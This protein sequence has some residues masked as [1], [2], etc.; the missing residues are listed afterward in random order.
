[1]KKYIHFY[2]K[3]FMAD[4][5]FREWVRNDENE[6]NDFWE[7]WL[8]EHPEKQQDVQTARELLL[9]IWA[10]YD[11]ISDH[12]INHHVETLEN[13]L[14]PVI[15]SPTEPFNRFRVRNWGIAATMLLLIVAG[16]VFWRFNSSPTRSENYQQLI[17]QS[18][19]ATL[20]EQ[21]NTT[22]QPLSINLPDGSSVLLSP[23]SQIVYPDDMAKSPE[24][25]VYLIGE[26]FFEVQRNPNKPFMVLANDIVTRVLG[27]SFW[28]R[29]YEDT[30]D[31]SVSVKTGK[32][33]VYPRQLGNNETA[34]WEAKSGVLLA[35]N[36]EVKYLRSDRRLVKTL[37]EN[38]LIVNPE[39]VKTQ[40]VFDDAPIAKVFQS[41]EKAYGIQIVYDE[42]TFKDCYITAKIYDEPLAET[43]QLLCKVINATSEIVDGQIVITG[44]GC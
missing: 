18:K 7:K 43:L 20:I 14:N 29:S 22:N 36:Q 24:R 15:S 28:V 25:Q 34:N 37:V 41:L 6:P 42:E 13:K 44:K 23:Q 30:P 21:K 3:D 39:I 32:V 10:T 19:T 33:S 11:H 1:M 9:A 8:L 17:G 16:T 31:V 4:S 2:T 27:T 26:A 38:P 12:E 35:H 5:S 40:A